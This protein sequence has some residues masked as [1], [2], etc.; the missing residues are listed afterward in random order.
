MIGSVSKSEIVSTY[1]NA[2]KDNKI[3]IFLIEIENF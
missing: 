2:Y 1:I 3:R